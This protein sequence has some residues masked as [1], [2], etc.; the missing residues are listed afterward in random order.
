MTEIQKNNFV[1]AATSGG[2]IVRIELQKHWIPH[3]EFEDLEES[4]EDNGQIHIEEM[5]TDNFAQVREQ[6]NAHIKRSFSRINTKDVSN[7]L[8]LGQ[9][10]EMSI[11]A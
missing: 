10:Q 6:Q 7:L 8:Q 5:S 3:V 9:E 1:E 11:N 4:E 2:K